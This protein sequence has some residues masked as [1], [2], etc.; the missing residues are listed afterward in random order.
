MHNEAGRNKYKPTS[1]ESVQ[2]LRN[3]AHKNYPH[4]K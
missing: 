3:N 2:S 1:S 4:Y